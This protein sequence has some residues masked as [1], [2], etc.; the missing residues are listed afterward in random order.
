[1]LL[2]YDVISPRVDKM[3]LYGDDY[4]HYSIYSNS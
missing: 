2:R 1:M 3:K 4:L